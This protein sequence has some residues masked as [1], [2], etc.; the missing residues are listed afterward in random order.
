MFGLGMGEILVI[1]VIA[2]LFIGPKKLPELAKQ[3]GRAVK[4]FK[5]AKQDFLNEMHRPESVRVVT[6]NS[7]TTLVDD[8]NKK[9]Q[10]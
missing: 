2:L 10:I 5:S 1:A 7:P 4:E 9:E 6:E 8:S 3:L